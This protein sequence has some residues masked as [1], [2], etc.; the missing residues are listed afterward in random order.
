MEGGTACQCWQEEGGLISSVAT[1]AL[2]GFVHSLFPGLSPHPEP[3][4]GRERAWSVHRVMPGLSTSST[5]VNCRDHP[6]GLWF[7]SASQVFVAPPGDFAAKDNEPGGISWPE[8]ERGPEGEL[9]AR[10]LLL[11]S[12]LATVSSS[13]KDKSGVCFLVACDR[14]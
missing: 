14:D 9:G 5:L 4:A 10:I 11:G 7:F 1:T 2:T 3:F 13:V 6:L 8:E 12:F